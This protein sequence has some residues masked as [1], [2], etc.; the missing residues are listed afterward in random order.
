MVTYLYGFV[1]ARKAA[2]LPSAAGLDGGAVRSVRCGALS[3]IVSSV[4]K[5]P[6]RAKLEDVR[7]HDAVLQAFVDDGRTVVAVRFGQT[8]PGDDDLGRHT[9]V[10]EGR[11]ARLLEEYDGCVEMRLLIPGV[12]EDP[13]PELEKEMGPG[14][15]YL[16]SLRDSREQMDHLALRG[17]IGPSVRAEVVERLPRSR[18]VVFAHLVAREQLEDYREAI[19]TLPA[20]ANANVVGPLALYSF[21]EPTS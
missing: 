13:T 4:E 20:L 2:R 5:T 21:A 7:T 8:F 1:L 17:A 9:E 14:R 15:A 6:A 19:S 16:E 10:R 11:L 3:A 12:D 18:G